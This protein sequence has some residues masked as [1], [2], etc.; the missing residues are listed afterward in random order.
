MNV[1][2]FTML[3]ILI[4]SWFVSQKS[5][6]SPELKA[7]FG[8]LFRTNSWQLDFLG[9]KIFS[10][11]N[12]RISFIFLIY[13]WFWEFLIF[14]VLSFLSKKRPQVGFEPRTPAMAPLN[15]SQKMLFG[16]LK[17]F[18]CLSQTGTKVWPY[19]TPNRERT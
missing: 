17:F 15:L 8:E 12:F 4:Q 7:S 1:I 16:Y 3:N 10:G 19:P 18:A 13:C 11:L 5:I 2:L 14:W 9:T 6:V